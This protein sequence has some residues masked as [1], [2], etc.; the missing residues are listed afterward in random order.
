MSDNQSLRQ[1]VIKLAHAVPE[2]RKHLVPI[3][4]KTAAGPDYQKYVEDKRKK[5]EEPL[6]KDEW[7]SKVL[8]KGKDEGKSK[9]GPLS[10][11]EHTHT[12]PGGNKVR[13]YDGGGATT[14]HYT[15]IMDG[16]DWDASANPGY[17]MSLGLDDN[18]GRDFSQWGEAKEGRH[19]GK[20]VKF[21][22]LD[23]KTRKHITDR[24]ENE[25]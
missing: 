17:K 20:P 25:D 16:K 5:H 12:L 11:K 19:L 21:T 23:E 7:E 18:G 22:D 15:V 1:A 10:K 8:G 9:S 6:K 24:V 2:M 3:L 4:R 14:D 13:V